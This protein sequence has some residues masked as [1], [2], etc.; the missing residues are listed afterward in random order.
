MPLFAVIT[1]LAMYLIVSPDVALSG[2][3]NVTLIGAV[4]V[5]GVGVGEAIGVGIGVV[6]GED[7]VTVLT[8]RSPQS[9]QPITV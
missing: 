6:P 8:S 9:D 4:W 3:V 2:P 7:T 5:G 1:A